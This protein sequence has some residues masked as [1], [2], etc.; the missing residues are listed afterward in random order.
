VEAV[1][2]NRLYKFSRRL[3]KLR[4]SRGWSMET[5]ADKLGTTNSL[6]SLRTS[7]HIIS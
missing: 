3:K 2:S 4:E 1:M 6:L 5:L 7:L